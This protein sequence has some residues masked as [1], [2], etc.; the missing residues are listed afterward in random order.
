M[1]LPTSYGPR[2]DPLAKS[3]NRLLD[4]A[5]SQHDSDRYSYDIAMYDYSIVVS[6]L[7]EV[8]ENAL[9]QLRENVYA[10]ALNLDAS[11]AKID[12]YAPGDEDVREHI[13]QLILQQGRLFEQAEILRGT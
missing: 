12:H 5:E 8:D 7:R 13:A 4:Y 3:A 1:N 9:H 10:A 11:I 6:H 2:W